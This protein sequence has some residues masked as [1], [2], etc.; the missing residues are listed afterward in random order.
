MASERDVRRRAY[1]DKAAAEIDALVARG[2]RMGG[3]AFSSVLLVK[4]ELSEAEKNDEPPFSGADGAAL[5]ASF[6]RLGYPPEDWEWLLVVD[7]DGASEVAQK[8]DGL[9]GHEVL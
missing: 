3:N 2:V 5:R 1:L 4:G 6:E 7:A 9:V 8:P